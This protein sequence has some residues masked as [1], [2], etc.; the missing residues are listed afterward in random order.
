MQR[1]GGELQA[2]PM[3][4]SAGWSVACLGHE[5]PPITMMFYFTQHPP[6]LHHHLEDKHP[7]LLEFS[8]FHLSNL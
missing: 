2:E 4:A 8:R 1:K 5:G 6:A 7:Q 3:T